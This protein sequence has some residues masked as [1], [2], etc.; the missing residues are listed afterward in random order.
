MVWLDVMSVYSWL[1]FFECY[2]D[3][4]YL[5]VLTNSF[6]TRRASD[7]LPGQGARARAPGVR[8][9]LQARRQF[10]R[11]L[12][13]AVPGSGRVRLRRRGRG[14][15]HHRRDRHRSEEHTSELQ[16]LMRISYA[17][18]CLKKKKHMNTELLKHM[19]T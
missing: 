6:P 3:H 12:A 1:F 9:A 8:L 15:G 10:G 5:H 16:S 2:C 18:F 11:G 7:L 13:A 17:V 14:V 19:T 4:L